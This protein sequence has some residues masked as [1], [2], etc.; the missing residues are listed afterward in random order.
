M[1]LV[2]LPAPSY[3]GPEYITYISGDDFE[4]GIFNLQLHLLKINVQ[5]LEA[6]M[7]YENE[8]VQMYRVYYTINT[9]YKLLLLIS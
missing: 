8:N 6:Y 3:A 2:F 7:S 9:R 5:T 1:H 4:V